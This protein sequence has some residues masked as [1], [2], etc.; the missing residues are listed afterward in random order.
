[1]DL[2]NNLKYSIEELATGI[3]QKK[4]LEASADISSKYKNQSGQGKRLV[5]EKNETIVYAIVRMPATYGAVSSAINYLLETV[6]STNIKTVLDVGSGT[7]TAVW[8]A[9]ECIPSIETITCLEREPGMINI[10]KAL[11]KDTGLKEK[12]TWI[13]S[14]MCA[15]DFNGKYDLVVASYSLNELA[16][17]D[18]IKLIEKLWSCTNQYLLIVEPGTPAVFENMKIIRSCL[19][20]R[21]AMIVAPCPHNSE[22]K[23]PVGDWCHF[24]SRVSRSK[25]HKL[26]KGGDAPFEDEKY[27]FLAFSKAQNENKKSRILR[28]PVIGSGKITLQL[29][30][31]SSAIETRVITK[32]DKELFKVARK[33][34]CG[35]TFL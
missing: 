9:C 13:Q 23:L 16:D 29:C 5:K 8:A 7:G 10:G 35:D 22:C 4:L 21:G 26:L 25:L 17:I 1:M 20:E 24:T 18:R 12:V 34:K 30:T 15:F 11:M 28:H 32:K 27:S 3:P 33:A 14:D 6:D 31:Q 19:I 2:P